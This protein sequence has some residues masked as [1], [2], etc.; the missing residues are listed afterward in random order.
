MEKGEGMLMNPFSTFLFR[1]KWYYVDVKGEVF[2][3][4]LLEQLIGGPLPSATA[5]AEDT[6]AG[7]DS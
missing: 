4:D 2:R 1:G 3:P 5:A 7:N 6:Q